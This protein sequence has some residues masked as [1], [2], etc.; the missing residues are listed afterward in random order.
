MN[1][2]LSM[3]PCG[4]WT[5]TFRLREPLLRVAEPGPWLGTADFFRP[6][7]DTEI[8]THNWQLV[9]RAKELDDI[10]AFLDGSRGPVGSV[11]GRGGIGRSRCLSEVVLPGGRR[12]PT[13]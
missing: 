10:L 2:Y 12:A 6:L 1:V 13:R 7:G 8:Y 11:I 4:W 9:G 3:T 5:P